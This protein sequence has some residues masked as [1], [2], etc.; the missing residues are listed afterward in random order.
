M[1]YNDTDEFEEE[2]MIVVDREEV[3]GTRAEV[4]HTYSSADAQINRG[5]IGKCAVVEGGA[6]VHL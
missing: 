6:G 4:V 1:K 3:D 2:C 5:R